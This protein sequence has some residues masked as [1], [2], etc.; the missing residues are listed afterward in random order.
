[1]RAARDCNSKSSLNQSL[2]P[3]PRF[4]HERFI[5][6]TQARLRELLTYDPTTGKF[7]ARIAFG[8]GRGRYHPGDVVSGN[9]NGFGHM[10]INLGG[11]RFYLHRLA[12][13]FAYGCW[14]DGVIDHVN[15]LPADNRI[16]NL[17]IGTQAENSQNKRHAQA[18]SKSGVLGVS[19][20]KGMKAWRARVTVKR[21]EVH[22]S[23]HKDKAEAQQAYLAAKRANHPFCT[24]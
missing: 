19:Y 14:P 4:I 16:D 21:V 22:V 12:W 11:K 15:G 17:R 2:L 8:R 7:T 5:M 20:H 6:I 23:Y 10:S 13:L 9:T 18:N 3:S 1:M 24:I